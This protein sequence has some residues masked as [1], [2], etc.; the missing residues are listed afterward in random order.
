MSIVRA[1]LKPYRS[2]VINNTGTNGGHMSN[3]IITSGALNNIFPDVTE[4][5]RTAGVTHY[6]KVF[7]KVA[8]DSD[9]TL[10]NPRVY[11]SKYTP[12]DDWVTMFAGTQSQTQIDVSSDGETDSETHYGVGKLNATINV[13]ATEITVWVEDGTNMPTIFR[14]G[15]VIRITDKT[16][17]DDVTG[18]QEFLTIDTGGVSGP[19]AGVYTLTVTTGTLYGYSSTDTTVASVIEPSDIVGTFDTVV[20]TSGTG[21]DYDDTTY[22]ILVDSIGGVTDSWTITFSSS[23][24]FSCSG[25]RS[26]SVGSGNI[27]T[28]F[29]PS[30]AAFTKPYF[31]INSAGWSGTFAAGNTMTFN[32]VAA[33]TALWF[34]RVVPAASAA[35]TSNT[36]RWVLD[37]ES[38]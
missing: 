13:G 7:H 29:A 24:A 9:L 5:E 37:G 16:D 28:S 10:Y 36:F 2:L 21:G 22:P 35:A 32:T 8:N 20:V 23:T 34:K 11:L 1:E 19:T 4:A 6:R 27:T 3:T 15:D 38:A 12:G 17:I 26:G 30:N 14:A 31:T 18:N 33:S 25:T